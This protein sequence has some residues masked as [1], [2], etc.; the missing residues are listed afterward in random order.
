MRIRKKNQT[1]NTDVTG[2]SLKSE[3]IED[4]LRTET[5]KHIITGCKMTNYTSTQLNL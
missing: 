2:I 4:N 1:L 3:I 5:T